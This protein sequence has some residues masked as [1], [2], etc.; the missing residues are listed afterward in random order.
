[1][2]VSEGTN[3][4]WPDDSL[5]V[6]PRESSTLVTTGP[7]AHVWRMLHVFMN[8]KKGWDSYDGL[9]VTVAAARDAFV[10]FVQSSDELGMKEAPH[11]VP[12]SD[13]SVQL[14]W[15]TGGRDIE[16]YFMPDGTMEMF[17]QDV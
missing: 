5:L 4:N 1:M 3:P 9:P 8:L 16:V 7:I 13:G 2:A 12:G 11:V 6:P 10:W 15:H 17:S 14:E